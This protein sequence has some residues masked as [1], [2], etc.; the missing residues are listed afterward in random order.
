MSA[1]TSE[2]RAA[3]VGAISRERD[4]QDSKWGTIQEHPHSVAEWLLI[5]ERKLEHAKDAWMTNRG[6]DEALCEL[7]KVVSV[8]FAAMEQHGIIDRDGLQLLI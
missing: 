8:G 2:L 7:L 3:I 4:Y 6:H 1:D 5:M